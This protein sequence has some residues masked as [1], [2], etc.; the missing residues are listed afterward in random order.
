MPDALARQIV[1]EALAIQRARPELPA[2]MVLDLV[3]RGRRGVTVDFGDLTTAPA[4]CLVDPSGPFGALLAAA[5]DEQ[6]TLTGLR[7]LSATARGPNAFEVY[8]IERV[9]RAFARRYRLNG[10]VE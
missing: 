10:T 2:L 6:V 7:S 3:M 5:F 8:W 1:D 4:E 9:M